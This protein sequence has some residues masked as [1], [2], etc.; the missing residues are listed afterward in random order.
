M[1]A[2]LPENKK[3]YYSFVTIFILTKKSGKS[4]SQL[5]ILHVSEMTV[6]VSLNQLTLHVHYSTINIQS[7][8]QGLKHN[9]PLQWRAHTYDVIY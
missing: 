1:T 7:D 5:V 8:I 9:S 3:W 2:S 6:F 4:V